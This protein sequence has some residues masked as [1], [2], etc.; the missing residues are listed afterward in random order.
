MLTICSLFA[1]ILLLIG[2]VIYGTDSLTKHYLSAGFG[3]T[4]V[5]AVF[6]IVGGVFM[7]I[8]PTET[9]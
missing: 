5:S 6:A 2:V 1:G 7:F 9:I 4:V 8:V 3:L